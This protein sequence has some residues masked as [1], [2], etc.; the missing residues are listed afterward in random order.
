MGKRLKNGI[1]KFFVQSFAPRKK[2]DYSEIFTRG[3]GA[4][5]KSAYPWLW[6]RVL[7][8]LASLYAFMVVLMSIVGNVVDVPTMIILG[9]TFVNLA[10]LV[11]IYELYPRRDTSLFT[12]VIAAVCGG[13][14]AIGIATLG[15]YFYDTDVPY[16]AELWTGFLE[17][18]SKAVATVLIIIALRRRDPFFCLLIGTAV[19][20]GFSIAEDMGYIYFNFATGHG[21]QTAVVRAVGAP[22]GHPMWAGAFGWAIGASRRPYADFKVYLTFIVTV[23][24]HY[25]WNLPLSMA[26]SAALCCALGA[27]A[28]VGTALIVAYSRTNRRIK[29]AETAAQPTQPSVE[30]KGPRIAFVANIVTFTVVVLTV[31]FILLSS[32]F[33]E[34]TSHYGYE[35]LYYPSVT[36]FIDDVQCG[37]EFAADPY[38]PYDEEDSEN[39]YY[40]VEK[41][42]KIIT[43]TQIDFYLAS[44]RFYYYGYSYSETEDRL[45]LDSVKVKIGEDEYTGNIKTLP[46][47]T[48]IFFYVNGD[49]RIGSPKFK[50]DGSVTAETKQLLLFLGDETITFAVL[51]GV[52]LVFGG[53]ACAALKIIARRKNHA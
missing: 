48:I 8:V 41:E 3:A 46:D 20:A 29:P 7:L 18:F 33:H 16:L 35:K 13:V 52:S 14:A 32:Y 28:T 31:C 5:G 36:E 4:E 19:G 30:S 50:E 2:C 42:G 9:G 53:A 1:K 37:E 44:G 49:I 38:R 51:A 43:A 11:L 21:V 47:E 25:C 26:E 45:I 27:V 24:L 10:Y 17:E 22:F 40:R 39:D 23:G 6:A 34:T 12:I 15:Y